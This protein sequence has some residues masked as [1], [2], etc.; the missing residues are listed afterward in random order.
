LTSEITLL[1]LRKLLCERRVFFST[2]DDNLLV[3][4]LVSWLR[5]FLRRPT[6]GILL[7]PSQCFNRRRYLIS[8][9][10][11]LALRSLKLNNRCKLYTIIPY[12]C[13][14]N[15]EKITADFIYDPQLWDLNY[16][17]PPNIKRA[18]S[19]LAKKIRFMRGG[20]LVLAFIGRANRQKG[21]QE[22][23]Q[24]LSLES[25]FSDRLLVVIAG[26]PSDEFKDM[27]GSIAGKSLI[28]EQRQITDDEISELY[29]CANIIWCAYDPIYDQFS[30]IFGRSIQYG[31]T[32]ILRRSSLIQRWAENEGIPHLIWNGRLSQ[33]VHD[34]DKTASKH[35][36][37]AAE[38]N[39]SKKYLD[40]S[41]SKLIRFR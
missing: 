37:E 27:L 14:P 1:I 9:F 20:R 39:R 35:S 12:S 24:A 26:Q 40:L 36:L 18:E 3:F 34:Y 16:S 41:V 17:N 13:F 15:A 30:G 2:A 38:R 23:I 5:F 32:P 6:S 4:F 11:Y 33:V 8:T 7:N 22:L 19:A 10:K 29:E 21:I 31:K 28:V 25:E